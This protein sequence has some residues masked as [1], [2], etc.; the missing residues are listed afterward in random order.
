MTI[1]YKLGDLSK[2]FAIANKDTIA[3]LGS[4]GEGKKHTTN[5][6][7]DELNFFFDQ[8]TRQ[9]MVESFEPFMGPAIA[10]PPR[11]PK[12]DAAQPTTP[13]TTTAVAKQEAKPKRPSGPAPSRERE[14]RVIDTSATVINVERFDDRYENIA[15]SSQPEG[16]LKRNRNQTNRQKLNQ[17]SRQRRGPSQRQRQETEAQRL[18]RIQLEKARKAQLRITIPDEISVGELSNRL[19]TASPT[20]IK[21]LMG[22]GHMSSVSDIIDYDTAS[23]VAEEMGAAYTREINVTIEERLNITDDLSGEDNSNL[24]ERPP[25]VVIMGHVDHGKTS[26]LDYIRKTNVVEGES[27]GITQH[28]GAYQIS[29]GEKQITFLDTPG[30]EA[31]T[32]MRARGASITDIAILV[33]AADDGIMPQTVEAINHAKDAN[34]SIIVA[35]NKIDKPE[36]NPARIKQELTEYGLVSEEWGGDTIVT[37]VSALTGE[38]VEELLEMI[39]LVAE[40]KEL[41]ANPDRLARGTVVEAKL[42]KQRGPVATILVQNGTLS[43]GDYVIAG[44]SVGRVRNMQNDSGDKLEQAGPSTPVEITGLVE[45]PVAGDSFN[46]VE[47]ER[48]ARELIARR[49]TE[50]QQQSWNSGVKITLDN[51][52][53]HIA[54]GELK[55]LPIIVKADV[56]GSAEAL[57]QSLEK[58]GNEEVRVRI[59]HDA[60]G[61]INTSDVMLADVSGAIIIG[62]NVRPD[63]NA[64][65]D[66]EQKGVEIKMYRVIYDAI[67]DVELAIRGMRAPKQREQE[68][69]RIEVREV[70]KISSV[71]TVAGCYVLSGLVSRESLIRVVR[72]G[73]II[74]DDSIA[75]LRRFKDDVS[76]VRESFECGIVLSR[77]ADLRV[78]DIFES[79]IIEEYM[80]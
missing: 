34:V 78:G 41:K 45:V 15:Q 19:K 36:A 2:D 52:F 28:I 43:L 58:L 29:L 37:N 76:Q 51:L 53:S 38:G 55:E 54:E 80:D 49:R 10:I 25:V 13:A 68:Q 8:I 22:L 4:F 32:S 47:N 42:D 7:D 79:Y 23:Y 64:R 16:D 56:Q 40:V 17:R 65:S 70:Y 6:T 3:I 50:Q 24:T 14:V 74:Q 61:A 44:T 33:V 35:I 48:L 69:G 77:F 67:E 63:N 75:T 39:M 12:A 11:A 30:H 62:F 71:G 57:K 66:S 31:F 21:I 9:N 72:D 18:E 73:I 5:L 1:T 59:I 20:V 26:L 60:V 27:G 46:A